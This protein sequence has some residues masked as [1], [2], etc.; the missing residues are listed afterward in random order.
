MDL[1]DLAAYRPKRFSFDFKSETRRE[2]HRAHHAQFVFC[3]TAVGLADGSNDFCFEVG[4][5]AH[6]I[7]HF[8]R[9]VPH[10]QA[11]DRKVAALHIFPRGLCVDDPVRVAAVTVGDV[12]AEGRDLHLE[13][14]AAVVARAEDFDHAEAGADGDGAAE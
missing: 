5:S 1:A 11:V 12:G 3:E 9:V 2:S 10:Q 6:E 14:V 13:E 4:L 8:S 7:E